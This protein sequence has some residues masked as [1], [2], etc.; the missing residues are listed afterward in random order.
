MTNTSDLAR[1][2]IETVGAGDLSPLDSLLHADL[3]ATVGDDTFDK[4]GWLQGLRRLLPA[5]VRNEIRQVFSNGE[6]AVVVYDFVT[7]TSA[8][9]VPCVEL[10]TARDGAITRIQLIFERLHWP[11]VL[12]ALQQRA[13]ATT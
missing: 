12:A 4:A 6:D 8:G 13:P 1:Q 7:D 2:Y 5:L 10:V 3:V 9:A 11:E